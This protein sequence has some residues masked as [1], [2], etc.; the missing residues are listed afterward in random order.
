MRGINLESHSHASFAVDPDKPAALFHNAVHGRQAEARAF[1]TLLRRIKRLKNVWQVFFRDPFP[2]IG[3]FRQ[4]KLALCHDS[5]MVDRVIFQFNVPRFN[6]EFAPTWH[7]SAR[8][9]RQIHDD[10]LQ[11]DRIEL[12]FAQIGRRTYLKFEVLPIGALLARFL[13]TR[14][15]PNDF[16]PN[17]R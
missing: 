16:F 9:C 17:N 8:I 14:R 10:L 4:D 3:H 11:L 7:C 6:S 15:L 5:V 2:C 13:S 12:H 1:S